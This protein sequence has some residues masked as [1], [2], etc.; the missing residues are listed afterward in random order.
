MTAISS[1]GDA[2]EPAAKRRNP[3]PHLERLAA[4]TPSGWTDSY[5]SPVSAFSND[6]PSVSRRSCIY[7]AKL[8]R[9]IHLLSAPEQSAAILALYHPD[10]FE[11]HEQ[12]VLSPQPD[13][14]PLDGH[15]DTRERDLPSFR[16]TV[17]VA[18]RLGQLRL[19]PTVTIPDP[20]A[21][22]RGMRVPKQLMGDLLLFMRDDNGRYCVNWTIKKNEDGFKRGLGLKR[23]R[24]QEANRQHRA[25]FRHDLERAYY[26]DAGIRTVRVT[27][28]EID[29]NVACNLRHLFGYHQRSTNVSA[30][31]H[32]SIEA[33]FHEILGGT[34][35]SLEVSRELMQKFGCS[36]HDCRTILYQAIWHRRLRVDLFS[37]IVFDYPLKQESRDV[38]QVY[39]DWFENRSAS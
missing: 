17:D 39:A 26:E 18:D 37:P 20:D 22:E 25:A 10:L 36:L 12:R 33:R 34:A 30:D 29:F 14:H 27:Q 11:L 28:E 9:D 5:E 7:S 16:G 6:A 23:N 1:L 4:R 13:F 8:A 21:P 31:V 3:L 38:L 24:K 19:H 32:Q 15:P 35:S 2:R